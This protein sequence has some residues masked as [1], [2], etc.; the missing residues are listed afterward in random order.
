MKNSLGH[1]QTSLKE[2]EQSYDVADDGSG[3]GAHKAVSSLLLA[4]MGQKNA[5]NLRSKLSNQNIAS[6]LSTLFR[7]VQN[8]DFNYK[9]YRSLARFV[10][11]QASDIEIWGAVFNLITTI[12]HTSPPTS[13]PPSFD[14]TPITHS[15]ASQQGDEQTRRA[16][17]IRIFEEIKDCTYRNV[18][19]F[20]SKYFEGKDWTERTE[21]IYQAVRNRHVDGRWTDF[22]DPPVQNAV[23][24]WWFHFQ[25][26]FLSDAQGAYYTSTSKDLI[27][28]E[29][30]RQVDL[31]VKPND[32]NVSK[33]VQD[34]LKAINMHIASF[35]FSNIIISTCIPLP[36]P[37]LFGALS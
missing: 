1:L 25:K 29:A 6:E 37:T 26:E 27:G 19:G 33:T 5:Y 8:R 9:Y 34:V 10:I 35:G 3:Q 23:L 22:P 13:I 18:E 36:Q 24:E 7:R 4:L 12:S 31:F 30:Q 15:S 21:K 2:A 11:Q 14:S 20:F 16:V 32:E 17:E 28:S